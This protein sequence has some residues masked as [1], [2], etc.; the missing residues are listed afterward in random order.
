VLKECGA[1][2]KV[3][4]AANDYLE[5]SL[6]ILQNMNIPEQSKALLAEFSRYCVE[7]KK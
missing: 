7:R 2:A 4:V 3:S 6:K 5:K 1:Q